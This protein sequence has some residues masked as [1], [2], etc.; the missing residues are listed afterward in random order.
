[1]KRLLILAL[2]FVAGCQSSPRADSINWIDLQTDIAL[3]HRYEHYGC[4][5]R[6]LHGYSKDSWTYASP[7]HHRHHDPERVAATSAPRITDAAE[8]RLALDQVREL[9]AKIEVL[10]DALK[11]NAGATN[12]NQTLIVGQI[13]ALKAEVAQLRSARSASSTTTTSQPAPLP[14]NTVSGIRFGAN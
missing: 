11:S 5:N 14:A 13:N 4:A 6:S 9:S 10:E 7:A 12:Q 1:M 8:A 3:R 2:V